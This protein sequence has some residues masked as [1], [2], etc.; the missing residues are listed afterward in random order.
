ME[1]REWLQRP[2]LRGNAFEDVFRSEFPRLAGYCAGLVGDRDLGGELAQEAL[3]RT[4]GRWT[5]V[6]DHRAYAYLIATN[7]VRKTWA[8]R[9]KVRPIDPT[10]T[11]TGISDIGY[12]ACDIRDVVNRLPEK[13][14]V[15][16]LLYY[17]ADLPMEEVARLLHRPAGTIRQRLHLARRL[18]A[19]GLEDG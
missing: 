15:P 3:A 16:T 19:T 6:R 8:E 5:S 7:L 11:A 12:E 18:L 9:A 13:L 17:Y 14:R 1:V 4:W 10:M 2:T